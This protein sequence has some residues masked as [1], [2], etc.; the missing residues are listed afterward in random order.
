RGAGNILGL[1]Q[2]GHVSAIGFHLYCKLLK[3]TI[4]TMQGQIPSIITDTKIDFPY[5]ARLPEDYVNEVGLRMEMYQ[6]LGEAISL[7]EVEVI[8]AEM[9]DRFGPAP[10]TAQWL[11]YMT[12]IRVQ[13]SLYGYTLVKLEKL[14]LTTEQQKDKQ[15]ITR[16]VLI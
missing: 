13:A 2:S 15:T 12:R 11:Y 16:K 3:R 7:D 1:E 5:D 4:K 10:E 6:R 9:Q 14:S 8:W